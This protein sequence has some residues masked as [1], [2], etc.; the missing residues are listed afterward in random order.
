M[1]ECGM[2]DIIEHRKKGGKFIEFRFFTE[3]L[4]PNQFGT[5]TY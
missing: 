4:W 3:F 5:G 1:E 2:G